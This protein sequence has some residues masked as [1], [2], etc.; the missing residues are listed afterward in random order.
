M[1]ECS[2]PRHRIFLMQGQNCI[3]DVGVALNYRLPNGSR[4]RKQGMQASACIVQWP[5]GRSAGTVIRQSGRECSSREPHLCGC[6]SQFHALS[7]L[8]IMLLINCYNDIGVGYWIM[9]MALATG[10][11]PNNNR[12]AG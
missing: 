4:G 11:I 1:A 5:N 7:V 6:E 12:M 10:D 2:Q 3:F 8:L 9:D